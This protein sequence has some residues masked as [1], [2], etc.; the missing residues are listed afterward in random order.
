MKNRVVITGL[1]VV[2]PNAVGL[3]AFTEAIK[4]GT[5]GITFHQSLKDK[6]FS[7]CIGGIPAIS[8]KKKALYLTPLQLRGFNSTSILWMK[9]QD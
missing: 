6:G 4:K 1:G 7:C 5:S 3:S 2:A 8:E 9:I